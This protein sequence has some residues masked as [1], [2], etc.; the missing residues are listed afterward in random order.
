VLVIDDGSSDNTADFARRAGAEVKTNAMSHGKGAAL[1]QGWEWAYQAGFTWAL[2][3]DG[4]G[5]HAPE[6]IPQFLRYA[7]ARAARLYIGNRM[8]Q[9]GAM[10]F[11]RRW[12]NR[13]MSW[14]LSRLAGVS[15]PDTQ[16]GFRL[17]HLKTW[18]QLPLTTDHFEV[19]SEV[20]L[21]CLAGGFPVEFV[22]VQAIYKAEHSKIDPWRDTLRWFR[23][24]RTAKRS[25][26]TSVSD[27]AFTQDS[28]LPKAP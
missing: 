9:A 25:T 18:S 16:C 23:W 2:T 8:H 20:L 27:P 3:L 4:D 12:V 28:P 24:W 21:A 22:P 26:G 6:D 17:L 19:E 5:Q 14:R 10:P 15:L 7:E 11:L 1:R 13:W